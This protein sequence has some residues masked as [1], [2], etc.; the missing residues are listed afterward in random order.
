MKSHEIYI[1]MRGMFSDGK[2]FA[3]RDFSNATRGENSRFQSI[4][5]VEKLKNRAYQRLV[6]CERGIWRRHT[7]YEMK[8]RT[9][10]LERTF[11]RAIGD[12]GIKSGNDRTT[13]A[14]TQI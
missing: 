10:F 12:D 7:N 2:I 9:C 4:F 3:L 5:M 6:L 13:Y 1:P 8:L 11:D 14:D